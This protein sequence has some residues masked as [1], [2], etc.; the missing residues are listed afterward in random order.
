[1]KKRIIKITLEFPDDHTKYDVFEESDLIVN[2]V[3]RLIRVEKE[4]GNIR[5]INWSISNG[6]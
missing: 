1:M 3:H 6:M 2:S 5:L 4:N